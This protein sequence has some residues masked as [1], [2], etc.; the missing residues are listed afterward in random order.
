ML[1][2]L[3]QKSGYLDFLVIIFSIFFW[4]KNHFRNVQIW[5]YLSVNDEGSHPLHRQG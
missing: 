4:W 3:R 1:L 5:G 2:T